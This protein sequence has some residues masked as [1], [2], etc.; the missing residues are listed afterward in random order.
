MYHGE[1]STVAR[2]S[3]QVGG[4][5]F[6]WKIFP[7]NGWDPT[8]L[9][10]RAT[11]EISLVFSSNLLIL[12]S[13]YPLQSLVLMGKWGYGL[14]KE[15]DE[16]SGYTS[17]FKKKYVQVHLQLPDCKNM[18]GCQCPILG[19]LWYI[20][21]RSVFCKYFTQLFFYLCKKKDEWKH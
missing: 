13:P 6:Y 8:W 14:K 19:F 1:F 10:F 2:K 7:Q 17:F 15:I 3:N 5:P 12:I 9:S 11:R 16:M 4:E 20:E 18:G 21:T